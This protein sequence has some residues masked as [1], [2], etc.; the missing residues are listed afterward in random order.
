MGCGFKV[1]FD[2]FACVGFDFVAT[3][4]LLFFPPTKIIV[5]WTG[6]L[7]LVLAA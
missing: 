7:S 4:W 6:L 3:P 2:F 5:R 1:P